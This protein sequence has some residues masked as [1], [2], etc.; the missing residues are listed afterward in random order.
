MRQC[1]ADTVEKVE[2]LLPWRVKDQITTL[3]KTE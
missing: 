1:D 2:A 3:E